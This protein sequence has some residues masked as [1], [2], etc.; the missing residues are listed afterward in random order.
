MREARIAQMKASEQNLKEF[1]YLSLIYVISSVIFMLVFSRSG[2]LLGL[3]V[4]TSLFYLFILPGFVVMLLFTNLKFVE[5]VVLG[6]V[7]GYTLTTLLAY[8]LNALAYISLDSTLL[9]PPIII[10][11]SVLIRLLADRVKAYK[12]QLPR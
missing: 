3:K 1:G 6:A 7:I 10:T 2:L 12:A 11:I 9:M 5:R 4:A 8:Y